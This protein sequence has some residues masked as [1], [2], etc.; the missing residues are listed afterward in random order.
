MGVY[1]GLTRNKK[2]KEVESALDYIGTMITTR[3]DGEN[4]V[5]VY[6]V[7]EGELISLRAMDGVKDRIR[8]RLAQRSM[9]FAA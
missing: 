9:Q 7:L 5:G 2:I 1:E 6:E 3:D 4:Y 8:Q